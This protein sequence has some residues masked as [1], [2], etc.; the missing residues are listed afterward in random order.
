LFQETHLSYIHS[1]FFSSHGSRL[2]TAETHPIQASLNE[3]VTNAFKQSLK[4]DEVSC[5]AY[6]ERNIALNKI[7][8]NFAN[9]WSNNKLINSLVNKV[10]EVL[11]KIHLGPIRESQY[12]EYLEKRALIKS[13]ENKNENMEKHVTRNK[14]REVIR[15]E[16]YKHL[17][18]IF[19]GSRKEFEKR[20]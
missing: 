9:L 8:T 14:K 12:R 13:D 19:E 3:K 10:T 7:A 16:Q 11:L 18:C 5:N 15:N 1:T 20:I 2:T 17:Q 4:R 6:L